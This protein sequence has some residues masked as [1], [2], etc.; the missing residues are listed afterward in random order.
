VASFDIVVPTL[1]RTWE[2]ER[3]LDSLVA[4]SHRDFRVVLTDQNPRGLLARLL[5]G[6]EGRLDITRVT[7]ERGASRGRNAALLDLR[8][9]I[10]AFADDDCWYPTDLLRDIDSM[11]LAHPEWDGVTGRVLDEVGNEAVAR[12]RRK[13]GPVDRVHVWTQGVAVSIFLRREVVECVGGF[14]ETLG[15]GA[16]TPWGSGEETDYLL[17]VLEAGFDVWYQTELT[18]RHAQTRSV[19]SKEVIAAGRSYGMGMGR[20]LRKH[21]YPWWDAGYHVGRA[22]GGAA[23]ALARGRT[24]EARFHVQVARGRAAGWL[25]RI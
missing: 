17:R 6:Y 12:W 8:G 7:S 25:A 11:L 15:V 22:A 16:G 9:D 20:V 23:F 4:Q 5:A 19:Y 24:G 14:D 1:G 13:P 18:A 3:F 10:V 2:L 21:R